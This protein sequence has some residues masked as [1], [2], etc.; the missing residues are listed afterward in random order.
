[1]LHE[2]DVDGRTDSVTVKS[3]L[4]DGFFLVRNSV[5]ESLLDEAYHLLEEFF[6]LPLEAK[7]AA[8]V[9][10]SNGQSGYTPPLV[11]T[12]EKSGETPDW[13]ELFHW[14]AALPAGHPLRARYPAR[15]PDPHMPDDLVPGIGKVL[16]ELHTRMKAFQ[17]GVVGVIGQALGVHPGYFEEMLEDGPVV[18]RAAWYPPMEGAPSREHVWAVEHQ[19]FDL[20][21]ALPRAT[22]PGLQVLHHEGEWLAVDAPEGYAVVNVGMV[23]ERLTDGLARAAVHRVVASPDQSGGRLSI[24]QFCHPTPW[25]V[26]SPLRLPGS[27]GTPQRFPTLTADALFE[28]TM[29]RINRLDTQQAPST[30][31]VS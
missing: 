21:T 17:V 5:P 18:N 14:G 29:Y 7:K 10:G 3:A 27:E 24:V 22:A 8:R 1:M 11:E 26:L 31:E 28:R 30:S 16:S 13:K 12:A 9:Q 15:Y 2:I 4:R 6:T 19:D 25:T 20:I 23:L